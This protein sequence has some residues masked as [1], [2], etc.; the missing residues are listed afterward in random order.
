MYHKYN[1][2]VRNVRFPC[3]AGISH[4]PQRFQA[5]KDVPTF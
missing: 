4:C 1:R 3:T 2:T 5:D